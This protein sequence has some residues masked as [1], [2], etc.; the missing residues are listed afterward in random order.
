[1][2]DI[3]NTEFEITSL[4]I[5]TEP[6]TV[7]DVNVNNSNLYFANNVLTHNKDELTPFDP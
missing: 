3:N 5:I 2:L 1:L 6:T 4:V 7:Y